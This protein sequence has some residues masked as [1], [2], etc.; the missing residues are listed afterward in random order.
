MISRCGVVWNE[1]HESKT[2]LSRSNA[3]CTSFVTA[4]VELSSFFYLGLLH[5]LLKWPIFPQF[6]HCTC[7]P[8]LDLL[9]FWLEFLDFDLLQLEFLSL[10]LPLVSRFRAEPDL[11]VSPTSLLWISLARIKSHMSLYFSFSFLV[12]LL[13]AI[14]IAS[15]LFGKEAKTN[16]A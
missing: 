16:S 9:L 10:L 7:W 12:E 6:Q 11:E 15:Q 14:I 2:Q 13:T 1:A 3:S 5:C 8:N 4:L